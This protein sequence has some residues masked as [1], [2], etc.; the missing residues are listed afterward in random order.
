MRVI[1]RIQ[2]WK[3]NLIKLVF[4]PNDF[5]DEI[6]DW[7][8]IRWL[9]EVKG[10]SE[11]RSPLRKGHWNTIRL[12]GFVKDAEK[13]EEGQEEATHHFFIIF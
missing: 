10:I 11:D 3:F 7:Q 9:E 4:T 13:K 1:T 5:A 8:M 6:W 12:W 2:V